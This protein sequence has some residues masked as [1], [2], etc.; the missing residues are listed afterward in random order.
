M[1]TYEY[2]DDGDA[3]CFETITDVAMMAIMKIMI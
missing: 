1:L 2:D 3:A